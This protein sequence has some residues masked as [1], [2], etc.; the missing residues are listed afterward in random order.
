[1]LNNFIDVKGY[2]TASMVGTLK[3]AKHLMDFIF[4]ASN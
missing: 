3:C 4:Y 1:M 2:E